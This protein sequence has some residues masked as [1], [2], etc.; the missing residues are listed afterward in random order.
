MTR[1]VTSE[2]PEPNAQAVMPD[3]TFGRFSLTPL[4][5]ENANPSRAVHGEAHG[6]ARG[7][8]TAAVRRS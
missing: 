3:S 4:V 7:P 8:S 6:A 2:A 1:P 5:A